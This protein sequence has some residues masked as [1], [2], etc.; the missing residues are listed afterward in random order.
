[1]SAP[2]S[3]WIAE[4]ILDE[5]ARSRPEGFKL[6]EN[7]PWPNAAR[8]AK[9]VARERVDVTEWPVRHGNL[10]LADFLKDPAQPL[11]YKAANGFWTRLSKSSL[12]RD[13]QFERDL[14]AYVSKRK[15]LEGR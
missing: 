15:Q 10:D 4:R 5:P 9:R 8:G 13:K 1:V 11:S 3:R 7:D 2:L 14:V 6:L 12:K